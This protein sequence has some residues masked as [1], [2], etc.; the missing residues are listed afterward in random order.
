LVLIVSVAAVAIIALRRDRYFIV[1]VAMAVMTWLPTCFVYLSE[2]YLY[3]PSVAVAALAAR[4]LDRAKTR[5]PLFILLLGAALIWA[6]HQ[7]WKLRKEHEIISKPGIMQSMQ[8]QLNEL[9][10]AIP[11]GAELLI[12]N[13]PGDSTVQAQFTEYQLRVQ[14]DDPTLKVDVLTLMPSSGDM[15]ENARLFRQG[16][17]V[18]LIHGGSPA[19]ASKQTS[20]HESGSSPFPAISYRSGAR[21]TREDRL[22]FTVEIVAGQKDRCNALRF[23]LPKA[24]DDYII[25]RF[26]A[27]PDLR[28]KPG[29]R[30]LRGRVEAVDTFPEHVQD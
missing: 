19:D 20:I 14:L 22:D 30:Q 2:R 28:M 29:Y 27:H 23:D 1:L 25:L 8:R 10:G 21:I 18:L 5:K 13:L 7:A 16:G 4:L 17:N 24:L 15:G 11:K 26:H 9:P 12:V 3:L 6:G